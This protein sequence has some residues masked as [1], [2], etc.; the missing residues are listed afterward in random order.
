MKVHSIKT[1]NANIGKKISL[2]KQA[3]QGLKTLNVLDLFAGNN[4]LW[5]SFKCDRYYGV[6]KQKGKGNNLNTDNIRIIQSLDLSGFNVIDVD[7][8]GIPFNQMYEL[9]NNP[10]LKSGTIIIYTCIT[11]K[12]SGLNKQCLTHFGLQNMYKKAKSIINSKAQELFY[13]Y[14][15]ENGVKS[16]YKYSTKTTFIKDYGY[17]IVDRT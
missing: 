13:A 6:E 12:M 1:D 3:T 16:I 5:S 9:F 2:R 8:Y 14:L 7:S 17:F 10:S 11:N 4:T 15:Q